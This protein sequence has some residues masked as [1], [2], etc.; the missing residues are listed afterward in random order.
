MSLPGLTLVTPKIWMTQEACAKKQEELV[1][2]LFCFFLNAGGCFNK[3]TVRGVSRESFY[4]TVKQ[5][6]RSYWQC[7]MCGGGREYTVGGPLCVFVGRQM[8]AS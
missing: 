3:K 7:G 4:S 8:P 6:P 5:L 1:F 2:C